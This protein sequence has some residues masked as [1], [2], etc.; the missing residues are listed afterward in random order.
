TDYNAVSTTYDYDVFEPC[1]SDDV[2]AFTSTFL[3][4][5]YS[6]VLIVGLLGNALVVLTLIR[7]KKLKNMTD[8]YLLNLAISDLLFIFSLPFWAYFAAD[9]W[10]FGDTMCKILSGI[11]LA[12]F[13]SGSFFIIL[14]TID[15]Y[16]AIVHAVLALK[17]RT[18]AYGILTSVITWGIAFLISVPEL[19]F[20]QVQKQ[21]NRLTCTLHFP[22]ELHI[23][24]NQF[25]TLKRNLIGLIL[26][27]VIMTFC[28]A[29]IIGTLKRCKSDKKNKAVRLI[30]IIIIVYFIFWAPYNIVLLLSTFQEAFSL[31]ECTSVSNLGIAV[32]VTET[33][34]MAHCCVNP[35]IYAFAGEKF[36]KFVFSFFR[37]YLAHSLTKNCRFLYSESVSRASSTYSRSTGEQDI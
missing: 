34:T 28:Y 3:P 30:F 4:T 25:M 11:Y 33:L 24:M 29:R 36:R 5:L 12:G 18:V 31:S 9:E 13:Y 15:R 19:M 16:L 8:I 35:V 17:T 32:Q 27:M 6:L 23:H 1:A 14:L 2:Q 22:P 7:F 26:P 37:K 20:K 10:V 21:N